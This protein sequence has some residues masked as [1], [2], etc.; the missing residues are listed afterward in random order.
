M[1]ELSLHILD[2]VENSTGAGADRVAVIVEE[3]AIQ[4]ELRIQIT[5]NG[6]GMA[7]AMLAKV[8]DPFVTSRTTRKVGLGIP[9]MEMTTRMCDG[10]LRIESTPGVGSIVDAVW[11]LTHLDR[12]PLGNMATTLKTI[13][14]MNPG[15]HFQ[16]RHT[17]GEKVFSLDSAEIRTALGD[18]PLT[19]PEILDWI[20]GYLKEN[21]SILYGGNGKH[22]NG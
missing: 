16:Y 11:R 19:Q 6:R 2:L 20:D 7:E 5:D 3:D 21:L 17:V 8:K 1:H 13:L 15:L 10:S 18:L 4:D 12:P 9:L 14:V 22:E